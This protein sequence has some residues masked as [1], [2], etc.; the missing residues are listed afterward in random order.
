MVFKL[1]QSQFGVK[2]CSVGPAALTLLRH[3]NPECVRTDQEP[4]AVGAWNR[5]KPSPGSRR[6]GM[7]MICDYIE[8]TTH[9]YLHI[10]IC[11]CI[12]IYIHTYMHSCSIIQELYLIIRIHSTHTTMDTYYHCSFRTSYIWGLQNARI[13]RNHPVSRWPW[14]HEVDV[15]AQLLQRPYLEK[16]GDFKRPS[17][18]KITEL[19][20]RLV[21]LMVQVSKDEAQLS[22]ISMNVLNH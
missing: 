3:G 11:M 13:M 12:Y 5:F 18:R 1:C 14:N 8:T 6:N 9:V 19:Y 4:L 10:G 22:L 17:L 15:L 20:Y 16:F 2:L 21:I 7:E